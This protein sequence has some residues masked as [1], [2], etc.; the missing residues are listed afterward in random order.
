MNQR[1]P[2]DEQPEIDEHGLL[3]H[4]I[5]DHRNVPRDIVQPD[6]EAQRAKLDEVARRHAAG[7]RFY[8]TPPP[9]QVAYDADG[10]PAACSPPE[11]TEITMFVSPP[12]QPDEQDPPTQGS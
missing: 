7:E 8:F 9:E 4:S 12:P 11:T 3:W 5:D 2:D 10:R 6:P 1:R